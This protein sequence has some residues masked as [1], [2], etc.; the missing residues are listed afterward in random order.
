[1]I[2]LLTSIAIGMIFFCRN[3]VINNNIDNECYD[4][5][6]NES[7]NDETFKINSHNISKVT[8]TKEIKNDSGE[9][10]INIKCSYPL[11]E[12]KNNNE[13]IDRINNEYMLYAENFIKEAEKSKEDAQ[14]LYEGMG[15]DFV[16]YAR[17]LDYEVNMNK[18]GL[19]SITSIAYY[20]SGGAHPSIIEMS[21]NFDI[22]K[23]EELS[24][25]E[26]IDDKSW[27]L[28]ENIYKLFKEELENR[29]FILDEM[30][31]DI[32]KE[33]IGSVQYYLK[34]GGI[35]LYFN[36]EQVAPYAVGAP[37]VEISYDS[38]IFLIKV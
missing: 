10:I 12:N 23:K 31:N 35:V 2:I 28:N 8:E 29:E 17:E 32:L 15:K 19:M 14:S 33:E 4:D 5:I 36:V 37:T 6:I 38:T 13:F 21:R 16:A 34:E 30:W 26:I 7:A 25:N 9:I 22:D 24:L 1:M 27:N 3:L 20:Y 18:D 11:I